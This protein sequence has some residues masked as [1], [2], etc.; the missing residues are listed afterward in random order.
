ML[1]LSSNGCL[2]IFYAV[3]YISK[4]TYVVLLFII[5]WLCLFRLWPTLHLD[6]L[7]PREVRSIVNAEC[8]SVDLKLTKD[9]VSYQPFYFIV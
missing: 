3:V 5:Q 4:S 1:A 2:F 9:Q 8:Q 6:P 7:S